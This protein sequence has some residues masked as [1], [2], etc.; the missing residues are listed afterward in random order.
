MPTLFLDKSKCCGC[1]AC[2][3]ICKIKST[4]AI[5]MIEDDEGFLY[6]KINAELCIRCHLCLKVC[7]MIEKKEKFKNE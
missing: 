7:P 2:Y 6:P 1:S 4:G 5:E 3:G